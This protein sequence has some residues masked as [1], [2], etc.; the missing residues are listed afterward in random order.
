MARSDAFR[1]QILRLFLPIDQA[2]RVRPEHIYA[3]KIVTDGCGIPDIRI[4]NEHI[5]AVIEVKT[6][7]NRGTTTH[8]GLRDEEAGYL[9]IIRS[10][11]RSSKWYIH[12]IPGGWKERAWLKEE[13]RAANERH[14]GSIIFQTVLW[15]E[16]LKALMEQSPDDSLANGFHFLLAEFRL[17]LQEQFDPLSFDEKEL[18]MLF[19]KNFPIRAVW[20]MEN[21]IDEVWKKAKA[22]YEVVGASGTAAYKRNAKRINNDEYSFY[23]MRNDKEILYFG[24]YSAFLKAKG[25]PI[26]F[27]V[28]DAALKSAFEQA[29]GDRVCTLVDSDYVYSWVTEQEMGS[30]GASEIIF[31]RLELIIKQ[32]V[33]VGIEV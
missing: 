32:L 27:G 31:A 6:N 9:Q 19:S 20:T 1:I 8:Q 18:K 15:E 22:K 10:D 25:F 23:I 26:C 11:R 13:Q 14:A 16:I 4:E 21:L 33:A 7:P 5:F 12:L 24:C 29:V 28:S 2:Q 3:H 17:L 30:E